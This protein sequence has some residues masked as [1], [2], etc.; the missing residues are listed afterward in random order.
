M[1]SIALVFV[2]TF[3]SVLFAVK[4]RRRLPV[5]R[6]DL[7]FMNSNGQAVPVTV[8]SFATAF[9]LLDALRRQHPEERLP[10]YADVEFR[11]E[12]VQHD[13]EL[14]DLG[15]GPEASFR[16]LEHE[17]LVYVFKRSPQ[18]TDLNLQNADLVFPLLLGETV[19]LDWIHQWQQAVFTGLN[20]VGGSRVRNYINSAQHGEN[21]H[22]FRVV[23]D[24]GVYPAGD[25]V[26]LVGSYVDGHETT[27]A[28]IRV[29]A[30]YAFENDF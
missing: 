4:S 19:R 13:Q 21:L 6:M 28:V 17:P 2:M 29:T 15:L 9:E 26:A 25:C 18:R 8:P 11:G 10:D 30:G 23:R 22:P 12:R 3:F 24:D 5:Q 1:R 14:A 7:Y 20:I 27:Q 16:V